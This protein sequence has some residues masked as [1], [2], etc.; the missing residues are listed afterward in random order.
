MLKRTVSLL[1][2][3]ILILMLIPSAALAAVQR[4][5][6]LVIGDE[7]EWV[8]EL[9]QKLIETGY[10]DTAATGYFG[11]A[12]QNALVSFQEDNGLLADGKAGPATRRAL[13]GDGYGDIPDTRAAAVEENAS[14]E[15]TAQAEEA[16]SEENPGNTIY[17]G[18]KGDAIS[19][20]QERLKEL[21]YYE[22]GSI[23][24]YYGPVTED[25]VKKFQRTNGLSA[26][27]IMGP[28]S[29]DLL[30]SDNAKYYTMYPKDHGNDI[31]DMQERL[32]EL[33][34]FD[35]DPTGYYGSITMNA[36]QMFQENNGLNVDGKAGQKTRSVLFSDGA[37][38][39]SAP[40]QD[41]SGS[42][43]SS[44]E[45]ESSPSSSSDGAPG[46]TGDGA[47]TPQSS[48]AKMIEIANA[49]VGK[50]YSYNS[51]GPNSFDC[52]GFMYYVMKNSGIA[53][54]RLSPASYATI[55]NWATITD[56]NSLAVGDLVFFKSDNDQKISHMGIYLGG[57]RFIHASSANEGVDISGMSSDYYLRNF[58][59]AKRIF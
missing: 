31:Y 51:N 36:V 24:G 56:K 39:L 15:P 21:E 4:H 47:A 48:V 26:D 2:A 42:G 5:E 45:N 52:S 57:G 17:P 11:T 37:K 38:P 44:Q 41:S 13:L 43:D 46:K 49:Q 30:F 53:T 14:A 40:S 54:S 59:T 58:V 32:R 12:T 18:D 22:Y 50:P 28:V 33:G 1:L 23:T 25:A 10:L 9:Q 7:D 27:G 19:N 34:Y 55:S 16:V 3:L 6:V 35:A 8:L 29:Y 20:I